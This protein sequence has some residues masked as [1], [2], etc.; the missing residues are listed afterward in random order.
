MSIKILLLSVLV[1][2]TAH[3]TS[4]FAMDKVNGKPIASHATIEA[5]I[6]DLYGRH[7]QLEDGSKVI[8]LRAPAI[9]ENG[10]QTPVTVSSKIN[11]KSI[12]ILT[13]S[14]PFKVAVYI[15]LT[16]LAVPHYSTRIKIGT[17][18]HI[19][20]I[21]ES[22]D[23]RLYS[24]KKE[25]I[26]SIAGCG[27]GDAG[28]SVIQSPVPAGIANAITSK[29]SAAKIG[30]AVGG[31]KDTENFIE[32]IRHG[33]LPKIDSLTYEGTFYQHYFD[34][35]LKKPCY[36]LFC[37]SYSQA[38]TK[39][40]YTGEKNY[41]L[42]VGLNSG[43]DQKQ[44]KR[45]KLNL[46]VVMDVSGSMGSFFNEYYYDQK[47]R[48]RRQHSRQA[49][50]DVASES[51]LTLLDQLKHGDNFGLVLFDD[52]AEVKRD[53]MPFNEEE[54]DLRRQIS[55]IEDGGGTNWSRGYRKAL[56]MFDRHRGKDSTGY[57]ED[58]ENRIVF[59][60]DAM[61]NQG[62][63]RPEGLFGMTS[64]ASQK[65]IHT[66]FIGVGLDFN[67]DLVEHVSKI[68][69]ANYYSVHSSRE[70]RKR[71]GE[72][73]EYMVTPL[74]YDLDLRL[75]SP[76]YKVM[77]VYGSPE[78]NKSTGQLIKVNTLFPSA[79]KAGKNKG[80]IILVKLKRTVSRSR[81]A[82]PIRLTVSY[83]DGDGQYFENRQHISFRG[84]KPFYDNSGIRKGILLTDYVSLL[85]DWMSDSR[86]SCYDEVN[87]PYHKVD[88][89]DYY[90]QWDQ[91]PRERLMAHMK[92]WERKSCKL[93]VS[94]GY[95]RILSFFKRHFKAEM[96][97]LG[98]KSL[99]EERGVLSDLLRVKPP[100][101]QDQTDI[102]SRRSHFELP[103]NGIRSEVDS[104]PIDRPALR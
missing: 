13:N 7:Y 91:H 71:M 47:G 83:R 6:K 102:N 100:H 12:A 87:Y 88:Y 44:F 82:E 32:N 37:P 14:G 89:F 5:A 76:H 21:V 33:Y 51:L 30:V 3:S 74:A 9:A 94:E 78:A 8:N 80:G 103:R 60:T 84:D 65:G 35:G 10:A 38:I 36:S 59:I 34:T 48:Q 49:K 73:F 39:N 93:N 56:S 28:L 61:P 55:R 29:A 86:A 64:S 24:V 69:G 26:V 52:T 63:L 68:E 95:H 70:F 18:S 57:K 19:I 43:I 79:S 99:A 96:A 40:I 50:I 81:K 54:E 11:A 75:D 1:I 92:T 25:V 72:E 2:L 53:L 22:W 27:G 4:V 66:S 58:Y 45:K 101:S 16:K 104:Y 85:K 90:R 46:V 23:G 98:D 41:Y 67:T 31:A 20:A 62:E 42:T 97:V 77:D 17:T 15:E